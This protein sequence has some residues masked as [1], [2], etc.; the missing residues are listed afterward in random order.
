MGGQPT[1]VIEVLDHSPKSVRLDVLR[2]HGPVLV[3]HNP[4]DQVGVVDDVSITSDKMGRAIVRF[5][6]SARAEEIFQD[7]VSGIRRSISIGYRV[8]EII[9]EGLQNGIKKIRA[10]AWEPFEISIVP[11]RITSL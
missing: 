8:F 4:N 5:G 11:V 10:V 3:N 7:V 6:K 1:E 9:E 2:A